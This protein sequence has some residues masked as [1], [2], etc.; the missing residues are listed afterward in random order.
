MCIY[1]TVVHSTVVVVHNEL[2]YC[3]GF[4][5]FIQVIPLPFNGVNVCDF[6][7]SNANT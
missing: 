3:T 6:F 2:H 1:N 7:N 4:L 5:D